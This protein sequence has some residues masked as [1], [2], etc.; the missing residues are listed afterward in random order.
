M[1]FRTIASILAGATFASLA[2]GCAATAPAA[3]DVTAA[4]RQAP[5]TGERAFR[6]GHDRPAL[7]DEQKAAFKAK[8]D[9][10][11]AKFDALTDEQKAALKA[12][13]GDWQ[14]KGAEMK[15]KFDAMTDEEKAAL[16]AKFP[17]GDRPH[18]AK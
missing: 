5:S 9:E 7:T 17:H 2:L 4:A 18:P 6:G 13:R 12:K 14:A 1:S 11:K 10:Q 3:P 8:A 15:A 16:K